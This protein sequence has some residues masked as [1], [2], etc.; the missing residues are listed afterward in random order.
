MIKVRE[1]VIEINHFPDG[2][3]A[4]KFDP[5]S[6]FEEVED[7]QNWWTIPLPIYW[8]YEK[9][10]ELITLMYITQHCRSHGFQNIQ[11]IM[12]YLPNARQDRTKKDEDIFTLKYFAQMINW[13]NFSSVTVLDPHSN[14]STAL[15]D[16]IE[17]LEPDLFIAEAL[18]ILHNESD[19]PI[20][21]FF[22]DEGSV[23]RYADSLEY[24]Y[25]YGCKDRDFATGRIKSL[26]LCGDTTPLAYSRVLIVDD[27]CSKGGTFALS[28]KALKEAGAKDINL[29]VT[30]CENTALKGTLF[31]G[32][33]NKV[34]TTSSMVHV[35]ELAE[36]V[37]YVNGDII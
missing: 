17:V 20:M 18:Q 11:L 9:E 26:Q 4:V 34:F 32:D 27:I 24:P 2:T 22:P 33:V 14:V 31:D 36:K 15:I 13:L 10:E 12:P 30:H 25:V 19:E 28:A 29:Y 37:I 6:T 5:F 8:Y 7:M 35:P 21:L 3:Q 1:Q 23:K 16:R